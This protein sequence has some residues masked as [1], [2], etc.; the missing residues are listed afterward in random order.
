MS[1]TIR[2]DR[3]GLMVYDANNVD[4]CFFMRPI[5]KIYHSKDTSIT[6]YPNLSVLLE[7]LDR[8]CLMT[9]TTN[10]GDTIPFSIAMNDQCLA[11]IPPTQEKYTIEITWDYQ[12]Q[13]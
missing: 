6:T 10:E 1:L 5:G 2:L 9:M 4:G 8:K 3:C 13:E 7:N 12:Y 11:V